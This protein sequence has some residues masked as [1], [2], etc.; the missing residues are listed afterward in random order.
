[1][2]EYAIAFWAA[3]LG[4]LIV[5]TFGTLHYRID[6]STDKFYSC[7]LIIGLIV[8]IGSGIGWIVTRGG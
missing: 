3:V 1:M 8:M 6:T 5:I 7:L 4:N 2:V